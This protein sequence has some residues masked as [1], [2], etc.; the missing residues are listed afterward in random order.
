MSY[1]DEDLVQALAH[2]RH[3]NTIASQHRKSAYFA[4]RW[5]GM[6]VPGLNTSGVGWYKSMTP[7]ERHA[8]LV[9]AESLF[10]KALLGIV[11]SGD[12]LAFLKE[13]LNLKAIIGIYRGLGEFL[14]TMDAEARARGEPEDQS[15]DADFRSGV[16]VGVG[17]TH[18]I[19]SFI[20]GKLHTIAEL[21][22][23]KGD[24][25]T[26]LAYLYRCG[27][28]SSDSDEPSVPKEH[29]GVRRP[30]ADMCLLI[31]HLVLSGF[32][33]H[34]VN[35]NM[36]QKILDWN[37]EKYP[38]GVFF[39]FAQGRM[40]VTRSQPVKAIEHYKQAANAQQQY[41]NLHLVSFWE[42]AIAHLALWE[43]EQSLECWNVLKAE[44]TWSK[45]I[46]AFGVAICAYHI[47]G[48]KSEVFDLFAM[49]PKLKQRIAGKSIPFEKFA[50]KRA[51]KF[52][53][54]GG[55]LCLATLELAYLFSGIAHAP[56]DVIAKYM[57]PEAREERIRL[58]ACRDKP[59][60]KGKSY[61]DDYC[62]CR[63]L[64]GVCE[65]FLAYPDPDAIESIGDPSWAGA[66]ERA[67]DAFEAALSHGMKLQGDHHLVFYTHYEYGRL[68]A[69]QGEKEEA[70]KHFGYVSAGKAPESNPA[71]WRGKYSLENALNFKTN[72]AIEALALGRQF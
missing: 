64:E 18:L 10:E 63:F 3:G 37:L 15:I 30:I 40:S 8:E 21:F 56:R 28:W 70:L 66:E 43:V 58:E 26:A 50:A 71:G 51:E 12:W 33:F 53:E 45:A 17:C 22:G 54:Q 42:I 4:T 57:L 32:T 65:R 44:G 36:A 2:A 19:L 52:Q 7:M 31:F 27:G 13:A 39:L 29:E 68:L 67:K 59:E 9:Y 38:N 11:Y 14:E 47:R 72:A 35:I 62:L 69:H 49:V 5:V 24:R 55:R 16:Y 41:R 6:V 48:G 1:E 60:G 23:Y 20:P 61:W 46:Y 34:G 25:M